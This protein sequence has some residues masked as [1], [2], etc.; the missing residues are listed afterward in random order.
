MPLQKLFFS[1]LDDHTRLSA[2]ISQSSWMMAGSG[3]SIELDA[4]QGHAKGSDIRLSGRVLDIPLAVDEVVTV[5]N[6]PLRKFW[7]TVCTLRL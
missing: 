1:L 3:M 7:E 2:H 4:L 5:Y 6:P